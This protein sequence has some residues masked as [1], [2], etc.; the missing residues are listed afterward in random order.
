MQPY[1]KPFRY[2]KL[3]ISLEDA[4]SATMTRP[5]LLHVQAALARIPTS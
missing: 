5:P 3:G 4:G 1:G 2:R